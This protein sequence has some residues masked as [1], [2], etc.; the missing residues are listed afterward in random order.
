MQLLPHFSL[1]EI[2][3]SFTLRLAGRLKEGWEM[4]AQ[5]WRD[6]ERMKRPAFFNPELEWK[7]RDA[8]PLHGK[9]IAIYA[10]QGL[11]DV[12]QFMRY[13]HHLQA[14]GATV[15]GVLQPELVTLVEHGMEGVLC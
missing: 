5:R 7:G 9:C 14:D 8:Q 12:I 3:L 2:D 1:A 10:E 11:G 15:V 6:T 13:V 4:Y